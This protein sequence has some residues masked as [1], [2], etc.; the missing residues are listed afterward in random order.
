VWLVRH[1]DVHDDFQQCAYGCMD[2]PLSE[3]G[4]MQTRTMGERFAALP[5]SLVA[6]SNLSRA[7]A[8][9]NAIAA[10]TH[11][12]LAID[13]RLREVSR[14]EWQG[15][16]TV[17][18]RDRWH[19]DAHNFAADPWRWKGHRGESDADLFERGWPA[20][21]ESVQ[22]A[23]GGDVVI[24]SHF[25]L[26]RALVTGALGWGGRESFSF[27]TQT[28]R[29]CLLIDEK[30]GWK[31]VARDVDDPRALEIAKPRARG[32]S[33]RPDPRVQSRPISAAA[34]AF[35]A[36]RARPPSL[37]TLD[38]ASPIARAARAPRDRSIRTTRPR[39][40]TAARPRSDPSSNR[41]RAP[42]TH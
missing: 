10:S 8:M 18:F 20:L 21:I 39:P 23:R 19:A 13:A 25:N 42:T 32:D 2:V 38:R 24:A 3:N 28:A 12:P 31:L 33:E 41:R 4:T 11:A 17:E 9:G 40:A 37:S 14:G 16:S 5:V 6:S 27:R 34:T 30:D 29:A 15:L 1:A 26:I 35:R 22:R 36:V 7:L